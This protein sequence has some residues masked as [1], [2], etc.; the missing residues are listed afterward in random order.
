MYTNSKTYYFVDKGTE[1]RPF[2]NGKMIKSGR[3]SKGVYAH[4][5]LAD[6][7]FEKTVSIDDGDVVIRV[8]KA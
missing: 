7:D 8:K 2:V 4:G 6:A 3:L 1:F 5:T